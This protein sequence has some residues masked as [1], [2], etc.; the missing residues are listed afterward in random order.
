MPHLTFTDAQGQTQRERIEGPQAEDLLWAAG[1]QCGR[2][3]PRIHAVSSLPQLTYARELL[4]LQRRYAAV[5]TQRSRIAALRRGGAPAHEGLHVHDDVELRA[6]LQGALR[7]RLPAP[8]LGAW[9][10]V[11]LHPCEWVALPAGLPHEGQPDVAHG[12]DMLCLYT[13][14]GAWRSRPAW[15]GPP[16]AGAG[17]GGR[18]L[19][20][21]RSVQAEEPRLHIAA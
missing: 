15:P 14:P 20:V 5:L 19:P 11:T 16:Q 2:W 3:A 1:V 9:L 8:T 12:V 6:V 17:P 18:D 10:A 4:A 7:L 13:R 21:G